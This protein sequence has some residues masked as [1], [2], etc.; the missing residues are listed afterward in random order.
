[1][2]TYAPV[3]WRAQSA[4]I[5]R[6]ATCASIRVHTSAY[7]SIRQRRHL[8]E[9]RGAAATS[10]YVS[11]RQH[12]PAEAPVRAARSGRFR[13]HTSAYGSIRQ[14]TPAY[15]SGG[16]CA[17]SAERPLPLAPSRR[18]RAGAVMSTLPAIE[19]TSSSTSRS[20]PPLSATTPSAYVSIRQHTSAYVSILQHTSSTSRSCPPLSATT[21]SAYA[22]IRQHT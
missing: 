17:S 16:T 10:A 3:R 7:V 22:S 2:L 5:S 14:H 11:I 19:S 6:A 9:Q 4:G 1:M 20:C 18:T 12:T 15:A 8:C 13:Y 21:P